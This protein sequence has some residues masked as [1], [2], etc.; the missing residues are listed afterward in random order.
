MPVVIREA[1]VEQAV[2]SLASR[3]IHSHFAGYLALV[4]TAAREGTTRNLPN[5]IRTFFDTFLRV[6]N[7]TPDLPYLRPFWDQQSSLK[8]W[9]NDNIAGSYSPVSARRIRPFME[10][11]EVEGSGQNGR[12]SLKDNHA[13][14]ALR[15]LANGKRVPVMP[16]ATFLYRDYAFEMDFDPSS[17]KMP[18]IAKVVSVFQYEFGY[19]DEEG[20]E[21]HSDFDVLYEDESL[22]GDTSDLF[23]EQ[24]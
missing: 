15:H 11:V 8:F 1:A 5:E 20:D 14:L 6:P 17:G 23:E 3:R 21:P 12:Y 2:A 22:A 4:R 19:A 7:G 16:L 13:A 9:Q 10:V 24:V 18:S